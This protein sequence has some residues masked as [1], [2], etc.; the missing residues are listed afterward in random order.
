MIK[1]RKERRKEGRKEGMEEGKKEGRKGRRKGR[2][3]LVFQVIA[4]IT[5][6]RNFKWVKIIL[7][8]QIENDGFII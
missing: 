7:G 3:K 8:N 6:F 1:R 4:F 2:L 5:I